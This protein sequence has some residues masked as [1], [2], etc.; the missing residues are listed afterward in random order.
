MRRDAIEPSIPSQLFTQPRLE[1]E[2]D[3]ELHFSTFGWMGEREGQVGETTEMFLISRRG[4]TSNG[5]GWPHLER[6]RE[7]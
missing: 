1:H 2:H 5:K 7:R 3:H 4:V 6:G